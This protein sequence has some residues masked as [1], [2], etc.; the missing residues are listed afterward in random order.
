MI[1][2]KYCKT[3]T[4]WYVGF[5]YFNKEYLFSGTRDLSDLSKRI[6]NQLW[7]HGYKVGDY[8]RCEFDM[9]EVDV[10]DMPLDKLYTRFYNKWFVKEP[11]D[12]TVCEEPLEDLPSMNTQDVRFDTCDD[13]P[14]PDDT[15]RATGYKVVGNQLIIYGEIARYTIG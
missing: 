12:A 8:G 13:Q 11:V 15:P 5:V 1:D 7:S 14:A 9:T 3:D 2:V 6:K 4:G 10:A